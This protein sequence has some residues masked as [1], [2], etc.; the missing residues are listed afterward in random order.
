MP[1]TV[2][3]HRKDPSDEANHSDPR[4][5][6][7]RSAKILRHNVTQRPAKGVEFRYQTAASTLPRR[8]LRWTRETEE[9]VGKD[10]RLVTDKYVAHDS[11]GE[12]L[13]AYY[14]NYM[15]GDI[16]KLILLALVTFIT[17]YPP[18]PPVETDIRRTDWKSYLEN[19]G[20]RKK[21]GMYYL[22]T[23]FE[24]GHIKKGPCLSKDAGSTN[25]RKLSAI[26]KFIRSLE[27]LTVA[28]TCLYGVLNRHSLEQALEVVSKVCAHH[29]PSENVRSG[30]SD[31]WIGRAVLVNMPTHAHCDL[32]DWL[33]SLAAIACFGSFTGGEF[34]VPAL[35]V[36]FPFQPRDVIFIKSSLLEH[37]I[38]EW[39]PAEFPDR[40]PGCRFSI[41]HYMHQDIVDWALSADSASPSSETV[42]P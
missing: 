25:S 22:A 35:K 29:P 5:W 32:G 30:K 1:K 7:S 4:V 38:T 13:V 20:G 21:V 39:E 9:K 11:D 6:K 40:Q 27:M 37:Y 28:L 17:E 41:V 31:A 36:K 24:Q 10:A 3:K 34:V 42:G 33:L 23:L 2:R 12:V 15:T 8:Q 19:C 16:V 26:V 18:P 14:P